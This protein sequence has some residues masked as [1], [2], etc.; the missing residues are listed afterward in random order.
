MQRAFNYLII[1]PLFITGI[2]SNACTRKSTVSTNTGAVEQPTEAACYKGKLVVRG[3]CKQRVVSIVSANKGGVPVEAEWKNPED[4]KVYTN[5]FAVSNICDFP[6]TIKE[7]E[8]FDFKP[9]APRKSTCSVCLAFI[10]VPATTQ[11]IETGCK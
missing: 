5:V 3:I 11:A 8:L 2:Y 4:G 7:G 6:D 9:I 1:I 10:P